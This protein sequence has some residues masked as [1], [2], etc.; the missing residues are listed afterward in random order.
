MSGEL[1]VSWVGEL[2]GEI[3]VMV[4]RV[5]TTVMEEDVS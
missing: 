2:R 3:I 5:Y 4:L 1:G